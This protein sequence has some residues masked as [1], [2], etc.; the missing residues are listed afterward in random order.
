MSHNNA[1]VVVPGPFEVR[2]EQIGRERALELLATQEHVQRH[3]DQHHNQRNI[4]HVRVERYVD[5]IL[6]GFWEPT[7]QGIALDENERLMDGQ[8]RLRA[9]VEADDEKPGITVVMMVS[10]GVKRDTFY[11]VDGGFTRSA[12]SFMAGEHAVSRAALARTLL[13]IEECGGVAELSKVGNGKYATHRVLRFLED[14]SDVREYG[15]AYAAASRA[16]TRNGKF[17][18]TS[19]VGLLVGGFIAGAGGDGRTVDQI[20]WTQWWE[21]IDALA[22]GGGVEEG[23]P[24]RALFNASP[25]GG[26]MTNVNYMRAIYTAAKYRNE[27]S[28]KVL[29]SNMYGKVKVW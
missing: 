11:L 3:S 20:K 8:H 4:S 19:A 29:R 18:G 21:D 2:F 7:H 5:D 16:A 27:E 6:D 13:R 17:V 9:V 25:V 15:M 23:N 28:I 26:N 1:K 12:Q 24:L 22:K 10:I 14:R